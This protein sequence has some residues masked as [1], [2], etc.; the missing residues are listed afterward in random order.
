MH[1]KQC[2]CASEVGGKDNTDTLEF[3]IV[4][5]QILSD[6]QNDG[7]L[8]PTIDKISC[9]KKQRL[10]ILMQDIVSKKEIQDNYEILKRMKNDHKGF[11]L[12]T[13]ALPDF[14]S[15]IV[16]A[17]AEVEDEHEVM[18]NNNDNYNDFHDKLV[19]TSGEK[20]A[21]LFAKYEIFQGI[22]QKLTNHCEYGGDNTSL[23]R[24]SHLVKERLSKRTKFIS[25][26]K[27]VLEKC[28]MELK[29]IYEEAGYNAERKEA[30]IQQ[31]E[32]AFVE[33]KIEVQPEVIPISVDESHKEENDSQVKKPGDTEV[34]K[35]E[36][37]SNPNQNPSDDSSHTNTN[38]RIYLIHT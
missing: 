28:N 1:S 38:P 5:E 12:S 20:L 37:V 25:R 4:K 10:G 22:R 21:L 17:L 24:V 19:H 34:V 27:E 3:D 23:D 6:I 14:R 8:K 29:E 9:Q 36:V 26:C 7:V 33:H 30:N 16:S 2:V 32:P 18:S 35:I 11:L 13:S 15:E 31:N